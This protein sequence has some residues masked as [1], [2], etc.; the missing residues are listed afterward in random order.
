MRSTTRKTQTQELARCPSAAYFISSRRTFAKIRQNNFSGWHRD[1]RYGFDTLTLLHARKSSKTPPATSPNCDA[2][3]IRQLAAAT[4]LMAARRRPPYTGFQPLMRFRQK[5]VY[6]I[7][8]KSTRLN[9]SH[10][11][12][13]YAVFC[14]KK[15]T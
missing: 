1:G 9:S 8:R 2:H 11:Y 13:S 12:I 15:K 3:T 14:L 7:D 6:M 4:R 5:R 10:G